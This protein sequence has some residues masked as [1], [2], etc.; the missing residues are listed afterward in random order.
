[1]HFLSISTGHLSE[2]CQNLSILSLI[3]CRALTENKQAN[4]LKAEGIPPYTR[5]QI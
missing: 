4:Y 1:L 5:T 2:L 3:V